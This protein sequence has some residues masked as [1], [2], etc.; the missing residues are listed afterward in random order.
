LSEAQI[1]QSLW[2]PV[3]ADGV[4]QL[5]VPLATDPPATDLVNGTMH[6]GMGCLTIPRH[7]SRPKPVPTNWPLTQR[8]PGAINVALYDG[9]VELVPLERL[10]QLYWS[11]DWVPPAKRPGLP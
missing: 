5:V 9:H 10:W 6:L 7:G 8:L 11:A 1:V 3:L 4:F 2:T